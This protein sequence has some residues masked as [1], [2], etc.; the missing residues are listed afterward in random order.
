MRIAPISLLAAMTVA[1]AQPSEPTKSWSLPPRDNLLARALERPRNDGDFQIRMRSAVEALQT[2]GGSA[3]S[4]DSVPR[5]GCGYRVD[6]IEL[7][8]A[9]AT[10][11]RR[12]YSVG[13]RDGEV[14]LTLEHTET[15]PCRPPGQR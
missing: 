14:V 4:C 8:G 5:L 11:Q 1:C 9:H 7:F 12:N 6:I 2:V 3:G 10:C 15:I 13:D